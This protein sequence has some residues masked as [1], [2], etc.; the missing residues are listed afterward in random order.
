MSVGKAVTKVALGA[1]ALY[2]ATMLCGSFNQAVEGNNQIPDAVAA[3]RGNINHPAF[4]GVGM[5][6]AACAAIPGVAVGAGLGFAMG[7]ARSTFNGP[8]Q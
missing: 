8:T 3:C 4:N 6:A 7:M 2:S 1:Y 5:R